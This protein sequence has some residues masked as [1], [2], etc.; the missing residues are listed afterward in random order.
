MKGV[1]LV[2][3]IRFMGSDGPRWGRVQGET[4]RE[5]SGA[6]Y[7]GGQETGRTG[8]L[9]ELQLLAPVEPTKLLCIGRN[10][11]DHAKELGNQAP[12]EP[13]FFLK[14][15]SALIGTGESV[16]V[17]HKEHS[18]HW[19]AELAVVIGRRARQVSEAEALSYVFGYTIANDISD[20]DL[21][22]ADAP[23]GFG[24]AKS[25]DTFCPC[26][27]VLVTEGVNPLDVPITLTC[28]EEVRQSDSTALM[29]H[30]VPKLISFLSG[31]MTLM[32]GD[33]IL[34]GTP[35]GVGAMQPGDLIEIT[36][37]GIGTLTNPVC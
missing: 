13:M 2:Q 19:E 33:V 7:A 32:P 3:Y 24:R 23:F 20:R 30:P 1:P 36:I 10:Y 22:K 34:T 17:P 12:T 26:G 15:P 37:P 8:M 9:S 5:L 28:N 4:V 31:I 29:I 21:Q 27:P 18:V 14:A 16:V 6:P 25:Y 11:A 35:K